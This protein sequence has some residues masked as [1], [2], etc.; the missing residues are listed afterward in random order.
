MTTAHRGGERRPLTLVPLGG[1]GEFGMNCA[2]LIDGSVENGPCLAID[3]GGRIAGD[4][5]PGVDVILPDLSQLERLGRRLQGYVVTHGHEDHIAALPHALARQP[6]PLCAPRYCLD[7][8]ASRLEQHG[9]QYIEQRPLIPG[10]PIEIGPFTVE[11]IAVSHS[12]P[13]S[14]ALAVRRGPALAIFSGDFRI[15]RDPIH[16]P[17]TDLARLTALGDAGVTLLF[18]DS[19]GADAPG[20]NPGERSIRPSLQQAISSARQRVVVA[21]FP[22]HAVRLRQLFE[23][24]L[25][26]GRQVAVV[27]RSAQ[28]HLA[29]AR[30]HGIVEVPSGLLVDETRWRDVPRSRLLVIAT[31]CQGERRAALPRMASGAPE[32]PPIER[33]DRVIHSARVIPGNETAVLR[34]VNGLLRLGAEWV[35]GDHGVHVSG[36]GY[37]DDLRQ[38]IEAT[39]PAVFVPAHGDRLHLQAHA[40]L[41][42]QVGAAPNAVALIEDGQPI[43]LFE[44]HGRWRWR[45]LPPLELRSLL[46]DDN[47]SVLESETALGE[48][49]HASRQGVIFAALPLTAGR[50]GRLGPVQVRTFGVDERALAPLLDEVRA[51]IDHDAG[52]LDHNEQ[53][54]P[55]AVEQMVQRAVRR[56]FRRGE[57]RPP[58]VV[59]ALAPVA[60]D[61]TPRR[62][63]KR[64]R[65][66]R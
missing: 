6:A 13:G 53:R 26:S 23:C 12:I 65:R 32:L 48:R 33:G 19:T 56:M 29:L 21:T 8:L 37:R 38:L 27:G 58:E 59:V 28:E 61:A 3:C 34:M 14:V 41:A 31:G 42:V 57:L 44:E 35:A 49:R 63:Q 5:L 10:Q 18:A 11:P 30:R 45:G 39:R 62:R 55:A 50:E 40:E 47:G 66:S 64:S 36:H 7:Q 9:Q 4:E 25:A 16:G 60:S 20:A 46:L 1:V 2:L 15:D 52:H 24:A 22:S 54:D 17:P 43:E 51:E